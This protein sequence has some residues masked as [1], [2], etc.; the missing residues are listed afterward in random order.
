MISRPSDQKSTALPLS[1]GGITYI[2]YTYNTHKVSPSTHRVIPQRVILRHPLFTMPR[3]I[4]GAPHPDG[5]ERGSAGAVC[6]S[7][8]L[9]V[10]ASASRRAWV[11]AK[12]TPTIRLTGCWTCHC[13]GPRSV[14]LI[15]HCFSRTVKR[16]SESSVDLILRASLYILLLGVYSST[17][18]V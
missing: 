11:V 4:K 16:P 10:W 1:Y 7:G 14:D 9:A 6:S 18:S 3:L 12:A 8:L 2:T 13:G 5:D 17:V 15:R